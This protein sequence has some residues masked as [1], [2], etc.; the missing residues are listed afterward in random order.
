MRRTRRGRGAA[1]D[2]RAL[3]LG[4]AGL[5][6][7][8]TVMIGSLPEG[9]SVPPGPPPGGASEAAQAMTRNPVP[10][11][12]PEVCRDADGV[13]FD[14]AESP[15]PASRAGGSTV[16]AINARGRLVIGVD[17]NSY[18]WG[19]REPQSGELV[20]F[21]IELAQAIADD[22]L[23]PG[24]ELVL[25]AIPT[26]ERERALERN[27]VDMVVR[28]MSITCERL[29]EVAFSIPYFQTGQQLLVPRQSEVTG[30]DETVDGLTVCSAQESTAS[31]ELKRREHNAELMEK[32]NHLDCLVQI[33]LGDADALMTDSALAAGHVAQDPSMQ[34]VG[35]E[36]TVESYGV[37]MR[38]GDD[39]LV[40]WVNAVLEDYIGDEN[41]SRWQDAFDTWLSD[42]LPPGAVTRPEPRY[43]D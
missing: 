22:V 30:L 39:D 7:A 40:R 34:L 15:Q 18:R 10:T 27:H 9:A 23:D 20:G 19:Y 24:G 2:R 31:L 41:D 12:A 8:G 3:L 32:P 17:Q 28:S 5:M 6:L 42:Y 4:A 25:R 14:P 21:D 13:P 37:A 33:Q 16:D 11:A 43:R 35:D 38:P 1:R 29:E 36:L 26:A